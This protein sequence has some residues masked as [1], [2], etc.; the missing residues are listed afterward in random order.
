MRANP[1]FFELFSPTHLTSLAPSVTVDVEIRLLPVLVLAVV[2]MTWHGGMFCA[3]L[4]QSFRM[5]YGSGGVCWVVRAR[6][7]CM[8]DSLVLGARGVN[9]PHQCL[10]V[11]IVLVVYLLG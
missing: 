9:V 6:S 8:C 5:V 11:S 3:Q 10:D 4:E 1:H 7:R 2:G